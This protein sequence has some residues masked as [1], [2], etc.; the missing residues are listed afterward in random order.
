MLK[1]KL[2]A[3]FNI[4]FYMLAMTIAAAISCLFIHILLFTQGYGDSATGTVC[5]D[6]ELSRKRAEAVANTL[7]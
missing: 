3:K 1:A 2:K 7:L 4:I 6:D 5:I